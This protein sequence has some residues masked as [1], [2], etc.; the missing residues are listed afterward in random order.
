MSMAKTLVAT[1]RDA[2]MYERAKAL[3]R[4]KQTS[5]A[6]VIRQ[7]LAEWLPIEEQ[8]QSKLET[9]RAKRLQAILSK[10]TDPF[11]E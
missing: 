4:R 2:E 8:R 10:S 1:A 5:V 11:E 3:A 7:A 6:S 9:G